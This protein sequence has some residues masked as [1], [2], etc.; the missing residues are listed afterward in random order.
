MDSPDLDAAYRATSYLVAM[1][2]GGRVVVRC[3]ERSE[4]LERFLAEAGVDH[5]AFLTACNPRSTRLGDAEN[6]LRMTRLDAALRDRG[7]EWLAGEGQGD[8]GDWPPEPSRLVLG[9]EEADAIAIG[10][11]FE[12]NAIVAGSRGRAARL[13]W[14]A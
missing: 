8:A 13:V 11:L 2:D 12:Q 1:P 4:P 9:I 7:R 3:G 5:W 14:I 6:A 10:R